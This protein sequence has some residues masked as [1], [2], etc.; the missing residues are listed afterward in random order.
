MENP[1]NQPY[2]PRMLEHYGFK[3]GRDYLAYDIPIEDV[4]VE[5]IMAMGDRIRKRFGF[6][7]EHVDFAKSNLARVARTFPPSSARR[8]RRTPAPC[9]P[10]RTTCCS[11]S[12]AS[13]LSENRIGGAGLCG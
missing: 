11:C 10:R 5:R 2:L 3:K 12:G 4:P 9:C 13:A 1:Y 8:R 6:Q 7:I